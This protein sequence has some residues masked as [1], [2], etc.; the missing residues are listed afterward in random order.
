[1][2]NVLYFVLGAVLFWFKSLIF[3]VYIDDIVDA[4]EPS[5]KRRHYNNVWSMNNEQH[6]K[7]RNVW[8]DRLEL[9]MLCKKDNGAWCAD[10]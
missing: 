5:G 4:G 9:Y 7:N 6:L 3:F 1:M 10:K 2:K 8:M